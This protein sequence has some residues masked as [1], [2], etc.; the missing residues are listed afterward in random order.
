[1][2]DLARLLL[3]RVYWT[4]RSDHSPEGFPDLAVVKGGT[5]HFLELKSARGRPT[6]AQ[7]NWL[8]ELSVVRRVTADVY[9]PADWDRIVGL[10][11]G[12]VS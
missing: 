8:E 7:A 6:V 10:L 5:L 12:D 11:K 1:V 2:V 9:R 3:W 4:H